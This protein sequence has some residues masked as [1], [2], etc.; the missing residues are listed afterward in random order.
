VQSEA[1]AQV[2]AILNDI[3]S[4]LFWQ[5]DLNLSSSTYLQQLQDNAVVTCDIFDPLKSQVAMTRWADWSST[6]D[7]VDTNTTMYVTNNTNFLTTQVNLIISSGTVTA[8]TNQSISTSIACTLNVKAYERTVV[9]DNS[10]D[11]V[12]IVKNYASGWNNPRFRQP[13]IFSK[14]GYLFISASS[15]QL[16]IAGMNRRTNRWVPGIGVALF[17]PVD[18]SYHDI[19]T[20]PMWCYMSMAALDSISVP[21]KYDVSANRDIANPIENTDVDINRMQIRGPYVLDRYNLQPVKNTNVPQ[22]TYNVDLVRGRN[23]AR[24]KFHRKSDISDAYDA[25]GDISSWSGIYMVSVGNNM[26][27]IDVLRPEHSVMSSYTATDVHDPNYSY[28]DYNGRYILW[29]GDISTAVKSNT[30]FLIKM[31]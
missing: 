26:D 6:A 12:S 29:G 27:I 20:Y 14:G 22:Y 25:G 2:A 28:V 24:L 23:V 10:P 16:F 31:G 9:P 3:Q 5:P 11:G 15:S 18:Q 19:R 21:R 30:K 17:E 13:V 4:L 7:T 8:R 1:V